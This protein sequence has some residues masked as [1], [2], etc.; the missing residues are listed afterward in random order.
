MATIKQ[1]IDRVNLPET[2]TDSIKYRWLGELD[3]IKYKFPEDKDTELVA[4]EP[5]D[6]IYDKYLYAMKDFVS[7]DL[8]NYSASAILFESAY[9]EYLLNKGLKERCKPY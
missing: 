3:G 2:I 6:T 9:Y 8:A 5:Y 1:V 7:G 4:K